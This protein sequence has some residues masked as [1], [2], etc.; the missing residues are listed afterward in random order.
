MCGSK[1]GHVA[2]YNSFAASRAVYLDIPV[3]LDII[4]HEIMR[5]FYKKHITAANANY[6]GHINIKVNMM[7]TDVFFI[8]TLDNCSLQLESVAAKLA[9][10]VV[11]GGYKEVNEKEVDKILTNAMNKDDDDSIAASVSDILFGIKIKY[12]NVEN[13]VAEYKR[14]DSVEFYLHIPKNMKVIV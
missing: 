6:N 3:N 12:S 9:R 2:S 5:N 14:H 4:A 7:S 11:N 8:G 1:G 13:E 10:C